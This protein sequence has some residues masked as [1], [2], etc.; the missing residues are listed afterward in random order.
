MSCIFHPRKIERYS[1]G[2]ALLLARTPR[3]TRGSRSDRQNKKDYPIRESLFRGGPS[4]VLVFHQSFVARTT[5]RKGGL[6]RDGASRANS[7]KYRRTRSEKTHT[8]KPS[9]KRRLFRGGPSEART[10]DTLIKN[11]VLYLLS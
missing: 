1:Q 3:N 10:P 11:Q 2:I 7:G 6:Y 9:P 5:K 4:N 8:K